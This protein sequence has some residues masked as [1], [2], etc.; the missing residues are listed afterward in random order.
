MS[1]A[2]VFLRGKA[3]EARTEQGVVISNACAGKSYV[4]GL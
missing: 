2:N 1:Q 4:V 3:V